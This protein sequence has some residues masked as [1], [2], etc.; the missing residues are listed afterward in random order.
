MTARAA[1]SAIQMV[2]WRRVV[3]RVSQGVIAV[4]SAWLLFVLLGGD[5]RAIVGADYRSVLIIAREWLSSGTPYSAAQLAGP[6]EPTGAIMM[7]PPVALLLFVPFLLLPAALWWA[8]PAALM[9]AALR[10]LDPSWWAWPLIALGWLFP[11]SQTVVMEGNPA[12][13]AAGAVAG[14]CLAGWPAV[15]ALTKPTL[16][17]FAIFGIWRRSWWVA[18][19]LFLVACAPFGNLWISYA[20]VARHLDTGPVYLVAQWPLMATPLVAWA[21][22]R[23]TQSGLDA[24]RRGVLADLG[25]RLGRR[26]R[27][28]RAATMG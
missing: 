14:G 23:P 21:G 16:A 10:K 6:F 24:S 25:R 20:T 5:S 9:A 13:W 8:V 28:D 2:D 15:L 7:Y 3:A 19:A 27:R 12:M 22:R 4:D 11:A 17:P 18:L 1:L 26:I